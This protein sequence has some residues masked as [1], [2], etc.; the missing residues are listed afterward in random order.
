M[1]QLHAAHYRGDDGLAGDGDTMELLIPRALG[2][3]L[4][5][6]SLNI[7]NRKS[8]CACNIAVASN[9]ATCLPASTVSTATIN[10]R[11][12]RNQNC[13]QHVVAYLCFFLLLMLLIKF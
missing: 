4:Q 11:W 12:I 5:Y 10:I 8:T 1:L 3:S 7:R 6:S 13:T 9:A 2:K